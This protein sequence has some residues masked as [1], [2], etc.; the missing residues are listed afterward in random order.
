MPLAIKT[1]QN[2][3]V[4]GSLGTLRLQTLYQAPPHLGEALSSMIQKEKEA[5]K[6][7]LKVGMARYASLQEEITQAKE[8]K[9]E[10]DMELMVS[11]EKPIQ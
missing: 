2:N 4:Q 7:K 10:L 8:E 6:S 3:K 5:L 9:D 1:I 11:K